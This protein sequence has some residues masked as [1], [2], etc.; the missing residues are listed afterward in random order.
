MTNVIEVRGL[1]KSYGRLKAVDQFDL[2]V[3]AGTITG[4]IGPNGAGKTTLLRSLLGL[5]RSS[6]QLQVMGFDPR[7]Q[8]SK[9]QERVCFIA[10]TATLPRWMRVDQLLDYVAAVHPRFDRGRAEQLL[11]PT[12]IGARQSVR[13]LSKGMNVQLHLALVMAIDAQLLILDEPTLGL[14]ILY[15]KRFFD[16]LLSDYHSEERSILI[17]THQVEEVEPILTDILFMERGRKVLHESINNVAEIYHELSV[18]GESVDRARSLSPIAERATR[19]GYA[20]IYRDAPRARLAALG[21]VRSPSLADLFVAVME[22][23]AS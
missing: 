1:T 21:D 5:A 11:A 17:S 23:G 3:A 7:R 16:Q 14:D 2:D 6:G 10:D 8:R 13:S 15:R 19:D 12:D 4:V 18:T 22:G 9:L 20:M